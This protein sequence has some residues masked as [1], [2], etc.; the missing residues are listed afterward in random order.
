MNLGDLEFK[1]E[2]FVPIIKLCGFGADAVI[3]AYSQSMA[4]NANRLLKERLGKPRP[5]YKFAK[6]NPDRW[7]EGQALVPFSDDVT[8]I[9]F[10][11]CIEEVGE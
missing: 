2:D 11:V 10:A 9:G 6:I 8:H 1:A 5:L 3:E 7:Y 4:N